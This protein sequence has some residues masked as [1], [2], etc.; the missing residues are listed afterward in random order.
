MFLLSGLSLYPCLPWLGSGLSGTIAGLVAI[1]QG[2]Q[3]C[4]RPCMLDVQSVHEFK[5][6]KERQSTSNP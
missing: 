2:F 3:S 1:H 6:A 4:L 5:V